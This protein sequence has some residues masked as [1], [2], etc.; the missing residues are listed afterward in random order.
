MAGALGVWHLADDAR[1]EILSFVD[2]HS[3][4]FVASM[5]FSTVK[6]VNALD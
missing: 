2:D 6:A 1:V 5:A 4:V 3:R